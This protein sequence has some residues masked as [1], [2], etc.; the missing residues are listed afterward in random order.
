MLDCLI[1]RNN[2]AR[3]L[4]SLSLFFISNTLFANEYIISIAEQVDPKVQEVES[5]DTVIWQIT[6]V[7][8]HSYDD[9][10]AGKIATTLRITFI[11]DNPTTGT[12]ILTDVIGPLPSN[13]NNVTEIEVTLK[14]NLSDGVY[15]YTVEILDQSDEVLATIDPALV[16]FSGVDGNGNPISSKF[17]GNC[18]SVTVS[19]PE[20]CFAIGECKEEIGETDAWITLTN[21]TVV[22]KIG[23]LCD[24][25]IEGLTHPFSPRGTQGILY[26]EGDFSSLDA[27]PD[28]V[29]STGIPIG[30]GPVFELGPF[31]NPPIQHVNKTTGWLDL[32]PKYSTT[33]LK[34]ILD[35]SLNSAVGESIYLPNS[36]KHGIVGADLVRLDSF[37]VIADEQSNIHLSWINGIE[38]DNAG[39]RIW[40]AI[41][42][43]SSEYADISAMKVL[44]ANELI[45]IPMGNSSNELIAAKGNERN[46]ATYSYVDASISRT[47]VTY[48]YLLEDVDV[49]GNHTF[50]CDHIDA[51]TVG[52]GPAIDLQSAINYCKEVTGS[53]D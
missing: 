21:L 51:V 19:I 14:A 48:Y 39:F 53:N 34:L 27:N 8:A 37:D 12:A 7:H 43:G 20:N 15:P 3:I 11:G 33:Q 45:V 5:N 23:G 9:T 6:T 46:G 49:N 16:V 4:V 52:Q 36:D 41:D 47:D 38:E 18:E 24:V 17:D 1:R 29:A 13:P 10:D 2:L 26:L 30:A 22:N 50:H 44:S 32:M 40:R 25:H 31:A 28:T 35:I 42:D